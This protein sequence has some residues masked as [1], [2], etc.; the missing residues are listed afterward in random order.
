MN[1]RESYSADMIEEKENEK[2]KAATFTG[3]LIS[4]LVKIG[5]ITG[6]VVFIAFFVLNLHT[7]SGLAMSPSVKDRDLVITYRFDKDYAARDVIVLDV[8][9]ERQV[10]RVVAVSG[11][12][13]DV[14]SE[15]LRVNGY[16]QQEQ[17]AQGE[18]LAFESDVEYPVTLQPGEI[19]VLGDNREKST[20]SRVYGPV[21]A[22]DTVGSVIAVFRYRDF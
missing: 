20:D 9:G 10:R 4:L 8:M 14:T 3:S 16:L 7:A 11:D 6:V 12:T 15:G 22:R 17:Y 1:I 2:K 5:I 19:F 18:T 13:V 21:K